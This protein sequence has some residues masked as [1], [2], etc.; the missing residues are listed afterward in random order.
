[1]TESEPS[2]LFEDNHLLAVRK[3]AGWLSMGDAT[4]DRSTV[5]WAADY[6]KAK[7]NK[8]GNVYVGVV[9]RL[10]RPVSGVLLFAKTSKA[11]ARLSDQFRRRNVAKAYVACVAGVPA[12]RSGV[13]RHWLRKDGDRNETTAFHRETPGALE[14]CVEY[15]VLSSCD[16]LSLLE[17]RPQTGRGHQLRVQAATSGHPIEGDVKYGSM[18]RLGHWIALHAAAITVEHPTLRTAVTVSTPIPEAWRRF[19]VDT[20]TADSLG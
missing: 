6:L 18:T 17:L 10:D 5:D 15:R 20:A 16:G 8:P 13:W 3:P 7:H 12:A 9:H 11:A 2:V 1:M 14:A 4:G 19:P